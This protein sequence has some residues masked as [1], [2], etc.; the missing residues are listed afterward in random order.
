MKLRW[1]KFR[2]GDYRAEISSEL[3]ACVHRRRFTDKPWFAGRYYVGTDKALAL[4]KV[5][6]TR[7]EAQAVYDGMTEREIRGR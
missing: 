1:K 3:Y 5:A 4:D 6:E 7:R 2:S